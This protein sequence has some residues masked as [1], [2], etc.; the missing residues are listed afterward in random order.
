MNIKK[1]LLLFLLFFVL[2]Y[3]LA[4]FQQPE[5]SHDTTTESFDTVFETSHFVFHFI[6]TSSLDIEGVITAMEGNIAQIEA[7][8][9]MPFPTKKVILFFYPSIE[10]KGLKYKNTQ[11]AEVFYGKNYLGLVKNDI[12]SGEKSAI[13]NQLYCRN[14]LGEPIV[15]SLETGLSVYFTKEWQKQG[16]EY[17]AGKLYRS[18]NLPPI[19]DLLDNELFAK[20]SPLVMGCTAGA[21]VDF[22]IQKYGKNTFLQKYKKWN[23]AEL[24]A[25]EKEWSTFLLTQYKGVVETKEL[26]VIPK[27]KGF[28]FAHEGFDIMNG[29]GSTLAKESLTVMQGIGANAVT[30]V[31]Y[32]YMENKS[33]ASFFPLPIDAGTETDEAVIM[34]NYEAQK[35]GLFTLLKPQ[36]HVEDSWPGAIDMTA[37]VEWN[38]FFDYYYRW[39]RHYALLAEMNEMG[40]L[41]VGVELSIATR[42]HPD[43]WRKLIKKLRGIYSGPITYAA[44]WYKEYAN[45]EFWDA[46]D[47]IGL[48]CYYPLGHYPKVKKKDLERVFKKT[49]KTVDK[50]RK[51]FNKPLIITEIGYRSVEFTWLKPFDAPKGRVFDEE[52]QKV[53]YEVIFEGLETVEWCQGIFWW[54]W[55]SYLSYKGEKNLSFSPVGK[56][57]EEVIQKYFKR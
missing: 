1:Q 53:C 35:L 3:P 4:A 6:D 45:I 47:Y 55:P 18:G 24:K 28:N 30:I 17:W 33:K 13:V 8:T 29:Y 25:L 32:T 36:I 7:F 56:S 49:L 54:K 15:T 39:I 5:P 10:S 20:E 26:P 42:S 37:E 51:H 23:V 11:P 34:A 57:T 41:S 21:F 52:A 38:T 48:D 14:L 22:L 31:P 2:G 19:A 44:N 12:F 27:L 16:F 40:M 46:V 50:T 43:E 9:Q